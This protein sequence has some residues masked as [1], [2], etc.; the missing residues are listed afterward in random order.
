[1]LALT[2]ALLAQ[3]PTTTTAPVA[4]PK[5]RL[6]ILDL[7]SNGVDAALTKTISDD[8]AVALTQAHIADDV[9]SAADLRAQLG[10]E[11][12]KQMA[13]C[14]SKDS[15]MAEV[16]Q[17]L[18][19]DLV[20]HGS[21]GRFGE[22]YSV[23]LS[24]FDAKANRAI[25]REKVETAKLE[26]LGKSVEVAARNLALAY[27]GKPTVAIADDA[28]APGVSMPLVLAGAGVGIVGLALAVATGAL[29]AGASSTLSNATT[30]SAAKNAAESS[31]V[32]FQLGAVAGGVVTLAGGG[33]VAAAFLME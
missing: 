7:D 9:T 14:E 20:V 15:C 22:V 18:G 32:P 1:M 4:T 24:L 33:L 23:A 6:V 27:R 11:A 30:S 17:A 26:V 10:V 19:A 5:T 13:G 28:G 31:E 29:A 3:T 25:A 16:A 12:T 21:A 2:L 8:V